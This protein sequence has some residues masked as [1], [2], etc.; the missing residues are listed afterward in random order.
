M[1]YLNKKTVAAQLGDSK[2][3][4]DVGG[5]LRMKHHAIHINKTLCRVFPG[6]QEQWHHSTV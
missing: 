3:V 5:C 4:C 1:F 2:R 6:I